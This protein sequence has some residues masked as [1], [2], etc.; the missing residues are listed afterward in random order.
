M[1]P[2]AV[3]PEALVKV[4]PAPVRVTDPPGWF[5][6]PEMVAVAPE[7]LALSEAGLV[8]NASGAESNFTETAVEVVV[9]SVSVDQFKVDESCFSR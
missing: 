4:R 6:A 7:T 3:V 5:S 1:V 2:E 8:A 9:A